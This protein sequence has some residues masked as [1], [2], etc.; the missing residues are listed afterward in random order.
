MK[1]GKSFTVGAVLTAFVASLCCLGPLIQAGLGVGA[2]GFSPLVALRPYFLG[3]SGTLLAG[4]FYFVYRKPKPAA[5]CEGETCAPESRVH[6]AA[7]PALWLATLAVFAFALFPYYGPKLLGTAPA[8]DA[9]ATATTQTSHLKI[10][11]MDCPTCADVIQHKLMA[12]PG[13]LAAVVRY[14]AGSATV[15]YDPHKIAPAQLVLVVNT[16]GYKASLDG[17]QK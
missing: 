13:V 4:G 10:A 11:N 17:T 3:L 15:K 6:R 5:A 2:A 16:T 9:V 1:A 14:P 12:T 8:K 7:K